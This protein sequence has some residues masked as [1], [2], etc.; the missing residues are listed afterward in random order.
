MAPSSFRRRMFSASSSANSTSRIASGSPCTKAFRVGRNIAISPASSSMV[1]STSSTA[2][3][4]SLTRCCA[5]FIA[6]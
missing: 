4:L 5:A 3:G 6:S 2:I 1:R